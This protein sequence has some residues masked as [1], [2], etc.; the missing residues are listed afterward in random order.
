MKRMLVVKANNG[1]SEPQS[2]QELELQ[3]EGLPINVSGVTSIEIDK[4]VP[5]SLV[6]ATIKCYVKLGD[7][8]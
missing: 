8:E 7:K 3:V 6:A 1:K 2:T 5:D 4:I